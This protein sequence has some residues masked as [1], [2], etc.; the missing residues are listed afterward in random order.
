MAENSVSSGGTSLPQAAKMW[1]PTCHT[2]GYLVLHAIEAARAHTVGLIVEV[3]Y[4]C[5]GCGSVLSHFTRFS[6]V[7][8]RLNTGTNLEGLIFFGDSY[9]HCGEPMARVP[10]EVR[11]SLTANAV[12][13]DDLSQLLD[14]RLGTKILRCVSCGF[15]LELPA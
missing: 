7:A 2:D 4:S 6:E 13:G 8:A 14:V 12:L 3:S 1:C 5:T 9:L 11:R 15:R 10:L